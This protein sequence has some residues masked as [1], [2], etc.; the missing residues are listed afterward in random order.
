MNKSETPQWLDGNG[1]SPG[2]AESAVDVPADESAQE[3]KEASSK[4]CS[5]FACCSFGCV[6]VNLVS[7][8]L[9]VLFAYSASV[10]YN[11]IDGVEW[12]SFYSLN[13]V[14]P[15][16]FLISYMYCFPVL[17][18]YL[19]SLATSVWAIV[20]IVAAAAMVKKTPAGGDQE[21]TGDNDNVTLQT[22]Y[23]YE[24]A[25]ASIA[26]ASSLYHSLMAK[27]CIKKAVDAEETTDEDNLALSEDV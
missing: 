19:L 17:A 9:I 6:C 18:I 8:V 15:A 13:A 24:L 27:F 2:A 11:D 1:E 5:F 22:E 25:G 14:I 10:Q 21:G 16:L 20:Y 23:I 12:V 3:D 7:I 26:L 4:K